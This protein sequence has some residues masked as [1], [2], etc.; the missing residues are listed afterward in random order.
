[1]KLQEILE[2][3]LKSEP[4]FVT[5]NGEV[6]KWVVLNKAKSLDEDLLKLLLTNHEL[7]NKFFFTVAGV[8]VFNQT[9]FIQFMEQ[10]NYL[11]DSYTKYK[12]K[13][14][15]TIN[16]KFI[17]QHN[18][19]SLVWPYKDC[20]L[21]GGQSREEDKREEIF[22]NEVLAQDEIT[23]LLDPKVLTNLK[24]FGASGEKKFENFKRNSNNTIT[25]NL[26]IKGNNLLGLASLL[27]QFRGKIKMIYIDPPYNTGSDSFKYNDSFSRSTWLTFMKNRIELSKELLMPSGIFLVQCS[28]HQY[29]YLR[30]MMD[31]LFEKHL[32]DLNIQVRHPDRSLTGDKE[33]NDVIEYILIYT[34][35]KAKKMPFI[36]KQKTIDDYTIQIDLDKNV[37]PA[38]IKCGSKIV[39]VYLPNQY[40]VV[41]IQPS[42]QGLKKISVRGSLREK[43][44]S[45][46]FF[47]K[48]L[49]PLSNYPPETLFKVP[50]MG[51]DSQDHRLFY[52]APKGNKNGGYYQGKPT[53]SEVTKKQYANFYNFEREYNN[54]SEQ[55]DVEFR[56]GKKPEELLKLLIQMF[57]LPNDTVLDYHLGSGTTAA[58]AHK[59]GRQYIG[60]EQLQSQIDLASNRINNVINGDLTG[61]SSSIDVNWQGGGSFIYIELKKY[62][63]TFI[64]QIEMAKD[65]KTLLNIW[66]QM[67]E[68]SFLNY[69]VD[70]KKQDQ[71][72]KEF[73]NLNLS[74]QKQLLCEVLNKNQLYVNLTELEDSM[75]TCSA[76]EKKISKEFYQ[77][78]K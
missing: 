11:N 68:K 58:V 53:S 47:V 71:H 4:N 15:L 1:M 3:Q 48:Y 9:L 24:H 55:G 10:K 59:L 36:E 29:A 49:E 5:D 44:S 73:K 30:V 25:D 38:T 45:G 63:Q 61:I 60:I 51:D 40:K 18:E 35:D 14:G 77:I 62:N 37:K 31:D 67:K 27:P 50:N 64:D 41:P 43:N 69:N 72:I 57:T 54:V 26:I 6:K 7:K 46:R 42:A 76:S 13:I 21:E 16:N 66:S 33:F 34:N 32:C 75:F 22:F 12:N 23:K 52:S 20:I 78:N 74:Q 28:F 8:T 19:V 56:N 65:S 2:E 39:E 70:I 17:K